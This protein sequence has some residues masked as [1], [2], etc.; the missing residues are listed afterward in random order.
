[1]S[2]QFLRQRKTPSVGI[3]LPRQ[4]NRLISD[5][6]I[7]LSDEA[8]KHDFPIN[9]FFGQDPQSY[10]E[11][12]NKHKQAASTG[13]ITYPYYLLNSGEQIANEI[14]AYCKSG[15]QALLLNNFGRIDLPN[16]PSVDINDS[17][18]AV[19]AAEHLLSKQCDKYVICYN[20]EAINDG[21]INRRTKA[22]SE[23]LQKATIKADIITLSEAEP[24]LQ[25]Y[26]SGRL[27]IFCITD[28]CAL[29]LIK[30]AEHM[31]FKIGDNFQV[32]G[33]D[34]LYLTQ[35]MSPRLTTVHQPFEE[36][37]QVAMKKILNMIHMNKQE[38]NEELTPCLLKRETA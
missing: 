37:G 29:Q 38:S 21:Y 31:N 23:A 36:M 10:T 13:I 20:P 6:V 2:A 28:A 7:G 5:L 17:A 24:Y 19:M 33:F 34:N 15:G 18:G 3:F 9:I 22:F 16:V 32:I 27:G 35:I 4:P 26:S 1:L 30:Q 25:E 8:N 14:T 11:F 12:I